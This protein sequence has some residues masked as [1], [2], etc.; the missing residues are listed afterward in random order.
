MSICE[1]INE[2]KYADDCRNGVFYQII[3]GINGQAR[4]E[5]G[6]LFIFVCREEAAR[7]K[8]HKKLYDKHNIVPIHMDEI[9][10]QI[11]SKS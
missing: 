7:Y 5:D 4:D 11:S 8:K 9:N 10:T 6:R 3:N 2:C 1:K